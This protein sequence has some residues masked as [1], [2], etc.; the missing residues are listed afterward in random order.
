MTKE[1]FLSIAEQYYTEMEVANASPTFY[2]YEK[3]MEQ[4]MQKMTC[5]YMSEHLAGGSVTKDRRR[6]KK[7][8][9]AMEKY[10]C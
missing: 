4:V 8:S 1:K 10:Q 7:H 6:K 9:P 3:S 2:D 5:E